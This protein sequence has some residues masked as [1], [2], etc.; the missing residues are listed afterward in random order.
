MGAFV[1]VGRPNGGESGAVGNVE[2]G[3]ALLLSEVEWVKYVLWRRGRREGLGALPC[4][5][6]MRVGEGSLNL[7]ALIEAAVQGDDHCVVFGVHAVGDIG[8][9]SK[10][11]VQAGRVHPNGNA[12]AVERA[13]LGFVRV[14]QRRRGKGYIDETRPLPTPPS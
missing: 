1:K 6:G 12:L 13:T 4:I 2:I 9:C 7:E 8:Y 11:L 14:G 5:V 10:A 3:A